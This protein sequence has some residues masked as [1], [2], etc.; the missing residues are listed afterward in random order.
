MP[1]L[2]FRAFAAGFATQAQKIEEESAKI[3]MELLKKAMDDFREEAKDYKP[4]YEEE[5]RN[6]KEQA[7]YLRDSFGLS[8]TQVKV[9]LDRGDLGVRDFV[10]KA[11]KAKN[12]QQLDDY[13]G[14]VKLAEAQEPI[15]GFDVI[16]YIDSGAYV[17]TKAPVYVGPEAFKTGVFGREV[18][19]G[20]KDTVESTKSA[21]IPEKGGY[22]GD[23]PSSMGATVDLTSELKR[24][25]FEPI[26][27]PEDKRY[28]SA[29][30]EAFGS[31]AGTSLL[32][33][34]DGTFRFSDSRAGANTK[35]EQDMENAYQQ[36]IANFKDDKK[37]VDPT[38]IR[39]FALSYVNTLNNIEKEKGVTEQDLFYKEAAGLE[40]LADT[41][42]SSVNATGTPTVVSSPATSSTVAPASPSNAPADPKD[43][44]VIRSL[45]PAPTQTQIQ[46]GQ[47]SSRRLRI[48]KIK[49]IL[50]QE[51]G[52]TDM[53]KAEADATAM[54][55]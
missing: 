53:K 32:Q 14:L 55:L 21:Y 1:A 18:S 37:A 38:T 13:K 24:G 35:L 7:T 27:G 33:N 15:T 42:G 23:V 48:A 8:D 30:T 43:H 44:P 4:K 49:N 28:R 31:F 52:Y 6:K 2:D 10:G 12:F 16:D 50:I 46:S 5:I 34:T 20:G 41:Q 11:E 45:I 39:N 40:G 22:E 36:W 25:A 47:G 3:G 29:F 9:L 17:K 19:L 51:Y 54:V 26:T